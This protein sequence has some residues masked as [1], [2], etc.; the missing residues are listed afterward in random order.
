MSNNANL[1]NSAEEIHRRVQARLSRI[2]GQVRGV[3]RMVQR[4]RPPVEVLQQ[5]ASIR[6]ALQ[7]VIKVILRTRLERRADYTARGPR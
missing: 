4:H 7:G 5:L 3:T 2:G 1:P 6:A